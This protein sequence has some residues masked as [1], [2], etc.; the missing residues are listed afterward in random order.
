V[1]ETKKI[2]AIEDLEN[3]LE[4]VYNEISNNPE[5]LV[6]SQVPEQCKTMLSR[7]IV[8]L[9]HYLGFE[10]IFKPYNQEEFARL[11]N[12]S[13]PT[14][15]KWEG[16]NNLPSRFSL[17]TILK[18]ANS[19]LFGKDV[20]KIEHILCKNLVNFVK[21]NNISESRTEIVQSQ[22]DP[23]DKIAMIE[24]TEINIL[25]ALNK[26]DD[27]CL[28]IQNSRIVFANNAAIN[29]F[30]GDD[31]LMTNF[32]ISDLLLPEI[33]LQ[34]NSNANGNSSSKRDL[35]YEK[36]LR[37]TNGKV[38]NAILAKSYTFFDFKPAILY[39]IKE[40]YDITSMN[41]T[42]NYSSIIELIPN[43]LIIAMN[44]RFEVTYTIG[45]S[46]DLLD[47]SPSNII[48]KK[49]D[50]VF[51]KDL[52]SQISNIFNNDGFFDYMKEVIEYKG[53]NFL[54]ITKQIF[55]DF[56]ELEGVVMY[57]QYY[58]NITVKQSKIAEKQSV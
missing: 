42:N 37:K 56:N 53:K 46:L 57:C 47:L 33:D 41:M 48:G 1:T 29:L 14:L 23:S 38:F 55:G 51:P 15:K 32:V 39:V 44:D 2:A 31:F 26:M 24:K 19:I 43:A 13:L 9:R 50:S 27:A 6:I 12:V 54:F 58:P 17:K 30:S 28:I 25:K 5:D 11:L 4:T 36:T 49:I 16:G 52:F 35:F 10:Q 3:D 20:I 45:K 34:I 40:T 8:F 18:F 22:P 7:N 21:S